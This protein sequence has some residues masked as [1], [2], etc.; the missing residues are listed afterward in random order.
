MSQI[1]GLYEGDG[2]RFLL[3]EN[4]GRVEL[5]YDRGD[6]DGP[7]FLVYIVYPLQSVARDEYQLEAVSPLGRASGPVSIERDAAGFGTVCR[8]GTTVYNRRFFDPEIGK[9]YRLKAQFSMDE[10][11][12]RAAA[13]IPPQGQST[14]PAPEL[15]N[16]LSLD[17][18]INVDIRY[19]TD[20]NFIGAPLYDRPRAY[21][22]RPAAEA[23]VRVHKKLALHGY[24]IIIHDAY[25]PWM[26][27]KM[28]WDATPESQKQFVADPA[29][30]SCHNRGGAVDVALCE[31]A[32]GQPVEM[33]S[34]YDEFSLRAHSA[35]P[36]GTAHQRRSRDA[37]R[38]YMESEGFGV[39][40]DE[41]WHFDYKDW[42]KY[43]VMNITFAE[44]DAAGG[45]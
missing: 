20:N 26:V 17:A 21:L 22:R 16:V 1:I 40:E 2:D 34:D 25:R 15:V 28:F 12:Q 41:W 11:R 42:R 6:K 43:P 4:D 33:L 24:G 38:I 45:Q 27:T 23:L 18:T 5:V 36:G 35:Y 7:A 39:Y 14:I 9:T 8:V 29:K 31:L 19:A 3:R 13:A 44:L 37:L 32:T 10:L 30:G